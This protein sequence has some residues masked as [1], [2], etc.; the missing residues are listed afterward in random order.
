MEDAW[1]SG[2]T[3]FTISARL[4]SIVAALTPAEA[5]DPTGKVFVQTGTRTN[6]M[7]DE[8]L[9]IVEVLSRDILLFVRNCLFGWKL[10]KTIFVTHTRFFVIQVP[11]LVPSRFFFF[12]ILYYRQTD[13]I[14]FESISQKVSYIT[15]K[16]FRYF[17]EYSSQLIDRK[18]CLSNN[19]LF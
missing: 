7:T 4:D 13:N 2:V 3:V 1:L 11:F 14:F 10:F 8:G 5:T 15:F 19:F 6:T 9:I 12:L 16:I 18:K 17:C